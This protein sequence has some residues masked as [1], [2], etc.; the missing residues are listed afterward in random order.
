ME[1][2]NQIWTFL[3][4]TVVFM[5]EVRRVCT[6]ICGQGG[7]FDMVWSCIFANAVGNFVRIDGITDIAK[8]HQIFTHHAMPI[9]HGCKIVVHN[10]EWSWVMSQVLCMSFIYSCVTKT[11]DQNVRP[12]AVQHLYYVSKPTECFMAH[13]LHSGKH[14]HILHLYFHCFMSGSRRFW[15]K[16][17]RAVLW[18]IQDMMWLCSSESVNFQLALAK[19]E[20]TQY[21]Y[22]CPRTK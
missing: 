7:G 18:K 16:L 2:W 15:K 14:L 17:F 5:E 11:N 13:C 3:V 6:A 19:C 4:H 21:A 22:Q 1:W 8:H 10:P 9:F 12:C 20:L